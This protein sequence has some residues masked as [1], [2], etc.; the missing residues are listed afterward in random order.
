[1]IPGDRE[2]GGE[3]VDIPLLC[4]YMLHNVDEKLHCRVEFCRSILTLQQ[5]ESR[6]EN[7]EFGRISFFSLIH[8][9]NY[10]TSSIFLLLYSNDFKIFILYQYCRRGWLCDYVNILS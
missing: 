6:R 3:C 1:M 7:G 5:E 9:S 8:N 10:V 2:G 4:Y